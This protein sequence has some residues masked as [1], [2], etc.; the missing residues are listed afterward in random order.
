MLCITVPYSTPFSYANPIQEMR[1]M[2]AAGRKLYST[3]HST[4][5]FLRDQMQMQLA[6]QHKTASVK[7]RA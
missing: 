6:V 3:A 7:T 2:W 4:D 1:A 5:A